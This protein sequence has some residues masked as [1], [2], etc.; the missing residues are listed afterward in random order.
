[1][2]KKVKGIKV[3]KQLQEKFKFDEEGKSVFGSSASDSH[4]LKGHA[5]TSDTHLEGSLRLH[6]RIADALFG[7]PR[8]DGVTNAT[9]LQELVTNAADF[10]GFMIYL[11]N[12]STVA[13]FVDNEKFYFCENGEWHPSPFVKEGQ[14]P[15]IVDTDGD[16]VADD[17]DAFPND[18]AETADS[19]GDGVGDNADPQPND[20]NITF[21]ATRQHRFFFWDAPTT[22]PYITKNLSSANGHLQFSK[23]TKLSANHDWS[24]QSND[25][26]HGWPAGDG[27]YNFTTAWNGYALNSDWWKFTDFDTMPDDNVYTM[28]LDLPDGWSAGYGVNMIIGNED[29]SADPATTWAFDGG[30]RTA[31]NPD[32][33]LIIRPYP[34]MIDELD[35]N[36]DPTGLKTWAHGGRLKVQLKHALDDKIYIRIAHGATEADIDIESKPWIDSDVIDAD[37]DWRPIPYDQF[38]DDSSDWVDQDGDGMGPNAE[39]A[40]GTLSNGTTDT[41]PND[42]NINQFHDY[43]DIQAIQQATGSTPVTFYLDHSNLPNTSSH[44]TL[45][46]FFAVYRTVQIVGQEESM[47]TGSYTTNLDYPHFTAV[48]MGNP[49]GTITYNDNYTIT[50]EN[51]WLYQG[52]PTTISHATRDGEPMPLIVTS[53]VPY[54]GSASTWSDNKVPGLVVDIEGTRIELAHEQSDNP[55]KWFKIIRDPATGEFDIWYTNTNPY[56]DGT[57]TKY[58]PIDGVSDFDG[59]GVDDSQDAFPTNANET[60]DTDGDGI[61]DNTD[62]YPNDPAL[63]SD[64]DGD[65]VDDASDAFPADASETTDTD[66]DGVADSSDPFVTDG[67]NTIVTA[68][69]IPANDPIFEQDSTGNILL[70]AAAAGETNGHFEVD[71]NG[72]TLL[73][74]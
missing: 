6:N 3:S 19:D 22:A 43:L 4:E 52:P 72:N 70:T 61:G 41:V 39:A 34:E 65:G 29:I 47:V 33:Y 68:N 50:A 2:V 45:S 60:T 42:S 9:E 14:A 37:Y 38:P 31:Q 63:V 59:D 23:Y 13:P 25:G 16:G 64:W 57:W 73:L 35:S 49:D 24:T 26:G 27:T 17:Q 40:L 62:D 71:A 54:H 55:N 1:M 53:Y 56:S 32:G 66:G 20:S 58:Y 12:A 7:L 11:T 21:A 15:V 51:G 44:Q 46:G 18:P 69:S 48:P 30:S 10:E 67:S 8:L 5:G 28:D 36:G 74:A